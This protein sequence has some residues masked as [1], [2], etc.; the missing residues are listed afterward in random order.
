MDPCLAAS[1]HS[2][3]TAERARDTSA[4]LRCRAR[5]PNRLTTYNVDSQAGPL[6][7]VTECFLNPSPQ[8]LLPQVI[9][10][11]KYPSVSGLRQ[12]KE[13]RIYTPPP[14]KLSPEYR[15]GTDLP[16]LVGSKTIRFNDMR[17]HPMEVPILHRKAIATQANQN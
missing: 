13:K 7:K 2:D 17:G 6:V 3:S 8:Q 14:G 11:R 10:L 15:A 9:W 16:V 1:A 12:T 5:E 4:A